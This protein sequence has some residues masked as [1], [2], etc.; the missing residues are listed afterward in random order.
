MSKILVTGGTGFI[1]SNLIRKLISSKNELHSINRN[2]NN[3]WRLSDVKD[4]INM[5]TVDLSDQKKLEKT[6]QKIKPEIIFH[7]A[8]CGVDPSEKNFSKNIQTN[9]IGTY[10]LFSI[11][12]NQKIK[13]IIN[14]GSVFEYGVP[15]NKYGFLETDCMN[16]LTLYGILKSA[17]TNL[18]DYF[19]NS[20]SL[21]IFTLRLFTP[22][23]MFENKGRLIS[24]IMVALI[25]KKKLSISSPKSTRDFIFIDDVIDALIKS[26]ITKNIDGKI[27]NIGLGKSTSVEKIIDISK[28]LSNFKLKIKTTKIHRRDYDLLGGKG[29][30][31]ISQAKKFLNWSPKYSV[32]DG[33][34]KTFSWYKN[35]ISLYS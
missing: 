17:Q 7:L 22:F 4:K 27:F 12:S 21:P 20:K 24:D 2:P 30:A 33:L 31:N 9:L 19:F 5:H 35:N 18:A 14:V 26:S 32:K 15:V 11:L 23:G 28:N 25:K 16:P 1:G 13:K 34:E 29:H 6:I 8:S 10:N 3:I